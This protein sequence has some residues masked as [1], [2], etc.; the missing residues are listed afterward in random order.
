MLNHAKVI[1]NIA[2]K[3]QT[4]GF[5]SCLICDVYHK[6][7]SFGQKLH[8]RD[9]PSAKWE[10]TK[11]TLRG[12]I[13][14]FVCFGSAFRLSSSS[15]P[16]FIIPLPTARRSSFEFKEPHNSSRSSSEELSGFSAVEVEVAKTSGGNSSVWD[17]LQL[18]TSCQKHT[19]WRLLNQIK[20]CARIYQQMNFLL[21]W[22]CLL[23]GVWEES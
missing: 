3:K 11:D 23:P 14:I 19:G 15:R 4:Y 13:I 10:R 18:T 21:F 1:L 6:L 8:V 16:N 2:K 12:E 7:V 9:I 20:Q 5:I 22:D 17:T